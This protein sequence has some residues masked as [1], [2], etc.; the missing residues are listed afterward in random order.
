MA[1]YDTINLKSLQKKALEYLSASPLTSYQLFRETGISEVSI[2]KYRKGKTEPNLAN[3]TVLINF[4]ETGKGLKN[5]QPEDNVDKEE[6]SGV[7]IYDTENAPS[8][9][10]LIPLYDDIATI[11]GKLQVG[12]KMEPD[13]EASEWI[14]PGSWF[15]NATDAIR[16]YEDSMIEYPSGCILAMKEVH[17]RQ[18]IIWGRDYVIETNEFRITKRVQRGKNED[19]IKAYSSNTDTYPD[20]QLIHEP[21]DIAWDDIRRMFLVLGHVVKKATERLCLYMSIKRINN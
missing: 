21:L 10:K 20:G 12:A 2:G 5:T 17:E 15:K 7:Q 8:G 13:T 4:F 18:L 1:Q 14:D 6:P 11:G 19:Y 16:H 9:K 3:S